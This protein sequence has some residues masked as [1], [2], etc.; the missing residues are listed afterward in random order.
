MDSAGAK[1]LLFTRA[2]GSIARYFGVDH[3]RQYVDKLITI[4]FKGICGAFLLPI[5]A[6]FVNNSRQWHPNPSLDRC[7]AYHP[8]HRRF[9]LSLRWL[10]LSLYSRKK[11]SFSSDVLIE[12]SSPLQPSRLFILAGTLGCL[13]AHACSSGCSFAEPVVYST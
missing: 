3:L 8:C 2:R 1:N 4:G 12:C 9:S 7:A 13:R 10:F 11:R 5:G 6:S